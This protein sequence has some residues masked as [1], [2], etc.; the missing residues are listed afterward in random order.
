[1]VGAYSAAVHI[2]QKRSGHIVQSGAYSART[3]GAYSAAGQIFQKRSGLIMQKGVYS[4]ET[5]GAYSAVGLLAVQLPGV[6]WQFNCQTS[7]GSSTAGH[8]VQKWSGH[9]V[10]RCI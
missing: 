4:A 7:H 3:V 5:V 6:K 8:I 9:I 2:V 1:M 10:Q